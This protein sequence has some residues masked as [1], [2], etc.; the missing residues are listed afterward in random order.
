MPATDDEPIWWEVWLRRQDGSE[1]GRLMEF[2]TLKGLDVGE[3]RLRRRA[4]ARR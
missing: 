3:R 1:L 2:A 4:S